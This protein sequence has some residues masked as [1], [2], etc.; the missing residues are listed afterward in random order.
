MYR[1]ARHIAAAV[2]VAAALVLTQAVARADR[3]ADAQAALNAW[4]G[5]LVVGTPTT[6]DEDWLEPTASPAAC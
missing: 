2:I 6:S 4:W 3:A 1:V 5:A